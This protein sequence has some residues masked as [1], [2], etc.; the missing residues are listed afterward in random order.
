M[1]PLYTPTAISNPAHHSLFPKYIAHK[2]MVSKASKANT[3]EAIQEAMASYVDGIEI[4]IRFSKDNVP[5]L[6][7]GDSLEEATNVNGIPE[8]YTYEQLQYL[9]YLH[10]EQ[11]KII[12]LEEVFKLVGSQKYLFLDIKTSKILDKNFSSRIAELIHKYHLQETVIVESFNPFFLASLRLAARDILLMYDFA[13]NVTA[14]GEEVQEQFDRIPWLLK[15]PFFQ[16]Q[17]RRIIRPDIVGPRWNLDPRLLESLVDHGYP[18]ICWTVDDAKTAQDLFNMGVKGIQTNKPLELMQSLPKA[19]QKVHDAGGSESLVEKVIY[20]K[21][22]HDIIDAIQ[23]AKDTKKTITI[24]GRR[25]SMGGQTL[26]EGSLHL[27][28]MR[29][30]HVHYNP[31]THTVTA[32]AGATWK[33]VQSILD[34]HGRSIKVMQS[35]NIFTVGGSI[36]ANVHGWQVGAPP[37]ASTVLSIKI[38]T[39]D[40]KIRTISATSTPELFKAVMGGYGQFGVIAE[41]ELMTVPNT[42]LKFHA[43]FMEPKQFSSRFQEYI[44]NNPN[45]ELVYGRLSVDRDHLFEEVGLFWYEKKE[46]KLPTKLTPE[47]LVAFKRAIFRASQYTE[48][49]KAVRWSAE[50]IYARKLMSAGF[51]TRNNAMNSDAHILWPLYGSDKDILQEYFIPKNKV[52]D[53]LQAL[54]PLITSYKMNIL[55]VTI[56]DVQK[57]TISLLPYAN[58]DVFGLVMLFSQAQSTEDER[59]MMEFTRKVIDEAIKLGGTFYLPYRLHFTKDQLLKSYPAIE[60]WI[61]VKEKWDPGMVFGSQFFMYIAAS[62]NH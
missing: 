6:Y 33:K 59:K 11:C 18:L 5:F 56:R 48:M 22:I 40:G 27:N 42:A 1:E 10:D 4:D 46:E 57:D 55:N 13:V 62:L 54:K 30:N 36:S 58:Q 7:H 8:S 45:V 9:S 44:T 41:V 28:M 60:A 31:E 17:V 23:E 16:K 37:I 25:H 15:Q 49:G 34:S 24:A 47:S 12:T 26:L 35:D 29:V 32:G 39:A 43:M 19:A 52:Y 51:V 21:D 53:F 61:R 14:M 2:S 3:L 38:I 50:K 20:V